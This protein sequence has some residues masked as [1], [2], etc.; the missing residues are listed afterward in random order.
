M[1]RDTASHY[2]GVSPYAMI[3]IITPKDAEAPLQDDPSRRLLL[4]LAFSDVAPSADVTL[5]DLRRMGAVPYDAAMALEVREL[6]RL[7]GLLLVE[8]LVIHC[9]AGVSRSPS[10]ALAIA[11]WLNLA[12]PEPTLPIYNALVYRLTREAFRLETL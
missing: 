1:S 6:V 3:S 11:E 10:M 7:S 9:D 12:P 4:R 5:E 2:R 8:I